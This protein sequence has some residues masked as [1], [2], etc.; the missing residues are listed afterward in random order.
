MRIVYDHQV[1]SWQEYGGISRYY[2][3][4]ACRIANHEECAVSIHA[5][6][7]VNRYIKSNDKLKVIGIRVP[8][9]P[10]TGKAL[11]L[12]N[13][14]LGGILT[15]KCLPDIIHETYYARYGTAPAK[16]KKVITVYDMI[17]ERFRDF[18]PSQDKTSQNKAQAVK[19]ANHI[20][21]ISENTKNDLINLF[22][23]S[24]QKI[25]VIYLGHTLRNESSQRTLNIGNKP[26][27]L[28]VGQRGFYKNFSRLLQA[29]S[30]SPR[31]QRTFKLVCFGMT[32]FSNDEINQI[33]QLNLK[34]EDV[35]C[36]GGDDDILSTLYSNAA[37][38]VF[39]S[40]YEGFG[41]SLL[42]AMSFKC[43]VVC[44]NKSS[45]P[46]VAGDAAEYFDPYDIEEIMHSIES[47]VFSTE[48][49]NDLI[50]KGLKRINL[51]SWEKC[52][53]QTLKVY[54]SLL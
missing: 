31:L 10:R 51:F 45:L 9:I 17:H 2:Y 8:T 14:L 24:P 5:P 27:I 26:Y 28:Y 42:E 33:K 39:P 23:V 49:R 13:A 7:Y 32:R 38:F 48:K 35:V 20:I 36:L 43:P 37:A 47:V 54:L 41:I 12:F 30:Y 50:E 1:F 3:E 34:T 16:V 21:C 53:E 46:E 18:L 6:L 25:S 11:T 40:L 29:Y 44:S 22:N 52:A 15:R 4:L 19:R